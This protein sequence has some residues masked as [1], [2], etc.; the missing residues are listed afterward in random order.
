MFVKAK[1][2]RVLRKCDQVFHLPEWRERERE[3]EDALTMQRKRGGKIHLLEYT[4][5]V[6]LAHERHRES[7]SESEESLAHSLSRR[8]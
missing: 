8:R 5:P 2:T 7:K 3:R 4:E 6:H 1:R